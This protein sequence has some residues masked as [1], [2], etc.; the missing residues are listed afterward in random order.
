MET[1]EY[2]FKKIDLSEWEVFGGGGSGTSYYHISDNSLILKLNKTSYPKSQTITEYLHSKDAMALGI[3]TP[4]VF[5]LVTDGERFGYTAERVR[6][7]KSFSRLLADDPKHMDDY[8][9]QLAEL[10]L[11]LHS[12]PF[13]QEKVSV[14]TTNLADCY[15]DLIMSAS[16][17]PMDVKAQL[18]E[19]YNMMEKR[20]TCLHGD[21]HFGNLL[22]SQDQNLWIDWNS[23]S[24]GD[25]YMDICN[26]ELLANYVPPQLIPE[27]FHFSHRRFKKCYKLFLKHYFGEKWNSTEVRQHIEAST[28]L[29][30][31]ICIANKPRSTKLFL[32]VL[33]HQKVRFAIIRFFSRFI[34]VN[35]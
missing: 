33:Q 6:N 13:I 20:T 2:Q 29:R 28:R 16:H 30:I 31:G 3:P 18:Q 23:F 11:K 12:T 17:I 8:C 27:L 22:K 14:K 35:L 32:P 5:D 34:K 21:L 15:I 25:P 1:N 9:R 7:K 10:T 4:K 24:Y 26:M 19:D